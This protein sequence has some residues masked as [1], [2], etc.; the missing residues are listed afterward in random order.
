MTS[1]F[2]R[3]KAKFGSRMATQFLNRVWVSHGGT[4]LDLLPKKLFWKKKWQVIG[5]NLISSPMS[6]L[7][8]DISAIPLKAF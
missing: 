1:Q 8:V 7:K 2:S 4:F 3:A 5:D 6:M